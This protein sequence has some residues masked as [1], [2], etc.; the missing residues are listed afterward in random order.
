MRHI[1]IN[2]IFE[3]TILAV[4]DDTSVILAL[5]K[6][7]AVYGRSLFAT[8][9]LQALEVARTELPDLILLDME[10]PGMDGLEVCRALK[11]N[12]ETADIP[13]LFITSHSEPGFEEKVFAVGAADYIPKPLNPAV[14]MARAKIHLD[15]RLALAKLRSLAQTDGLTGVANRR[16]FDERLGQEWARALRQQSPLSL[17]MIDIDEF[18]KYN[19]SFGHQQGDVCL[20]AVASALNAAIRRP[21][22]FVARFGGEEFVMLLPETNTEGAAVMAEQ[23]VKK[24]ES[25]G[26]AHAVTAA[27][28]SI[29]ISVGYAALTPVAANESRPRVEDLLSAADSALYQAKRAGRNCSVRGALAGR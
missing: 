23:L 10:M 20:Q 5:R 13:V 12:S 3:A 27:R 28:P 1:S 15:N 19:D 8:S 26:L 21:A 25:L 2:Q 6:M 7:L 17:L 4:D 14:V 9:G 24:V 18:K 11:A 16:S 29:T 22:D